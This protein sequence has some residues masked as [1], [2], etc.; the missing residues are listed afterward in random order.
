MNNA[1]KGA[2]LSGLGFPGLGQIVLK[3]YKRGVALMFVVLGCLLVIALEA[4]QK[5]FIIVEKITSGGA[6]DMSRITEAATQ[7]AATSE[8]LI[9]K[10][11]F[12][13]IIVFW[14]IGVIDAYRI[15]KKKDIEQRLASKASDEKD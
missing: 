15:G 7:G 11:A 6:V 10:L 4:I 5:A 8:S 14:N 3:F 13:L 12:F 1:L 9:T 2:L